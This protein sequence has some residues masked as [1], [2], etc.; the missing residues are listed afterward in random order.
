V[1]ARI[2]LVG[3][4]GVF[5]GAPDIATFWDNILDGVDAISAV[6]A[7]RVDPVYFDAEASGPDRF[8]CRR[9]GFIDP[10]IAFDS[11]QFGI[12]PVAA[13]EAEPEQL[14]ALLMSERALQ[15]AGYGNG[16][17]APARTGVIVGR[18]GYIS[19][20]LA[21]LDQRVRTSQQ[22]VECLRELVPDLEAEQLDEARRAFQTA[23]G[24]S[25]PEASIGLVPNLV[26][27][28]V[29]NRLD[30]HGPAY[31]IDAA[32][33]SSL[34]A[35][36]HA[37]ELLASGRCDLMLAGGVH[38]SH[39]VTLWSVF[40]Q[41]RALS[42]TG[43]IRPF[44]RRA[45]G[46]LIGEGTGV[47]VLKRLADAE[48]DDDR[49]YAVVEGIGVSSDGRAATLMSP[50]VEGEISAVEQAWATAGMDPTTVGLIEAHGTGTP[51]GDGVEL[52][53]IQRVFGAPASA[54][55]P[56]VAV[57]SVKSMIGHAMPACGIAGLMKGALAAHHGV[58]PPTLHAEEPRP[59]LEGTRFR[60]GDVVEEWPTNS[61][62]RRVG[63][64][65][66]GFGG[67]NA[68]VVLQ[69]HDNAPVDAGRR[70]RR[71]AAG[72]DPVAAGDTGTPRLFVG[73]AATTDGLLR[74]L[75]D[76]DVVTGAES[77]EELAT[78]AIDPAW[79]RI[80]IA[81]PTGK[82][83]D[84]ARRVL[85]R[86]SA[87]RGRNDIW[88]SPVGLLTD[89]GKVAFA[90][91]GVEPSF[92]AN[93]D[94]VV[95][96]FDLSVA[97]STLSTDIGRQSMDVIWLGRVLSA[98]LRA[99]GVAPDVIAGHSLGEWTAMIESGVVPGPIV[100]AYL[101]SLVAPA[102]PD[103]VFLAVGCGAEQAGAAIAD[104]D[105]IA[106]SHDN[107][108]HQAI[109][110][111]T[112]ERVAVAQARLG[113]ARVLCQELPFRT[114]FHT[115]MFEPYA[116]WFI[117]GLSHLPMEGSQVPL[118]SAATAEP[119][120]S[121]E[122][123]IRSMCARLYTE[124]VRF[125]ELVENLYA[126]GVRVFV[127][128]GQGS[129]PSFV[130]DTLHDRPHLAI[131]ASSPKRPGMSQL[132]RVGAALW[133]E[134]ADV[135]LD[136]L[137]TPDAGPGTASPTRDPGMSNVG[138]PVITPLRFESPLVHPGLAPIGPTTP[139]PD[140]ST[141]PAPMSPRPST[142]VR[143]AGGRVGSAALEQLD[144]VME[145]IA[146]S[147]Q[148][149]VS[150]SS[151]PA[152]TPAPA[153]A[154]APSPAHP[155]FTPRPPM[156]ERRWIST[157]ELPALR[158]HAFFEQ[159]PG[160]PEP[161]D[162]FVVMP[163][164][165]MIDVMADAATQ[166]LRGQAVVGM[167]NVRALRWLV[168]EP[169]AEI[170]I[171]ARHQA[172]GRV[173]VAIDGYAR[174]TVVLADDYAPPPP[175]DVAPLAEEAPA[176]HSARELYEQKWMF[177]GPAYHGITRVDTYGADGVRG[178][179][180]ALPA[181]GA[182][183]DAAGQLLGYW[184]MLMLPQ[185]RLVLPK[186]VDRIDFYGP[187]P[188]V[189]ST[190]DCSVRFDDIADTHARGDI[191]LLHEG[192]LWARLTGFTDHRFETTAA[193]F[194]VMIIPEENH[195]AEPRDGY[196][197]LRTP[198]RSAAMRELVMRRYLG[199]TERAEYESLN[200]ARQQSFLLGRIALK[201]AV[202]QWL[203]ARGAGVLYPAQVEVRR[204]DAG[205][206]IVVLSG[207]IGGY[208]AARWPVPSV[209]LAHNDGCATAAVSAEGEPVGVDVQ[210]SRA[211]TDS[212][213]AM[214]ITPGELALGEDR[215][216]DEWA[217]QLWTVKEAVGKAR[218]TGLAGRP[219]DIVI[220]EV[221]GPWCRVEDMWVVTTQ[222]DGCVVSTVRRRGAAG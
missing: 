7:D 54:D 108:P 130:D 194:P 95:D 180:T 64:S 182:L 142:P 49:I 126:D 107:C 32:C 158:D 33:A 51:I 186:R 122:P 137:I 61:V 101:A 13:A 16:T 84:L 34:L 220:T 18:G 192:R 63:V 201:D 113:Q 152:T 140:S 129:V 29:A 48:R 193:S 88:F 154:P 187:R 72:A 15:D 91:P 55:A 74:Q 176:L 27:S 200:P 177:H 149:I 114:G 8:Y 167:E 11:T 85:E 191:D 195:L 45:D 103:L 105:D 128:P 217:T 50:S 170:T 213:I 146:E 93:A 214:A 14:L 52:T 81:D 203:A 71:R 6:P 30:L 109:L 183:L 82:R 37:S 164:T 121:D 207:P 2:A 100:D 92:E 215:D 20:G 172:P 68:H 198:W 145:E 156:I 106:V 189:G 99:L 59:E 218:R 169:A 19:P 70:R 199:A 133:V 12:M 23:L 73:A 138:A 219:R 111:G 17:P 118:W 144:L 165:M 216:R 75:A 41:L 115:P 141:P 21:R 135:G 117:E 26:A 119:F 96:H 174:A 159:A 196:W 25:H 78:T 102:L 110:C 83:L 22:L 184:A 116:E 80:A 208:E 120:P 204:G 44:D 206:P 60:L 179:I 139:T 76:D 178:Q 205:E 43:V 209:S 24:P 210:G 31:T 197:F 79:P 39:D 161:A 181:P 40:S 151:A 66:F 62:P 86:G 10:G 163:V 98:A 58:R 104:L 94:D 46:L 87:W 143:A 211:W 3:M 131:A 171:E 166:M 168:V 35:V 69:A 132:A 112:P 77:L 53:M 9:G 160:W 185:D 47:V 221:D 136:R 56:P 162:R 28:R 175:A 57:G 90:F 173:Q 148:Q 222:E 153:P 212:E 150:A 124:P 1:E 67:I 36:S 4:A 134:G 188:A 202:R 147:A 155:S 127:Q 5:P 123:G 190:L 125:R 38:H 89:G 42:P 97:R 65:A 157:A